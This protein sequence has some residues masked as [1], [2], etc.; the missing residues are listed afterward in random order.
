MSMKDSF[1]T[2]GNTRHLVA[3]ELLPGLE[4]LPQFEL[5]EKTLPLV[6][7]GG[8]RANMALP[9][10]S[11]AQQAV[12]CEQRFIPS[13]DHSPDVR[14]LIYT[15]PGNTTSA[16]LP[17]YLHMHGGGYVLGT[18]EISDGSNRSFA[19]ELN[20]IIVSVDYRL[21]PETTYPGALEDCYAALAWL[22]RNAQQLGVDRSRIAIGGES[23]GGGHAAALALLARERGEYPI[24][25]Q[26]LD[27]PMIDDRTGSVS[28][29]HPHCGEFVW[30]PANNRFG[31]RALL[32]VEPGS[33]DVPVAAVPARAVDL[34]GLPPTFIAVG[35]LDLF[36]EEDLEYARRLIRVGVPTEL[37]VIPGAYHG[38]GVAGG[39]TPQVQTSQRLRRAALA[40][41]FAI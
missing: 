12:R 34:S 32:G 8:G 25:L 24:C 30:P 26:L 15:P 14:V 20:C 39:N 9:A 40:R 33:A 23:A 35:A 5:S 4:A 27:A 38:F 2:P 7:G 31:W 10:L 28:E 17:A 37:Y 29:P 41:A 16:L 18:P 13:T 21:A 19:A 11:P 3:P 1:P 22:H 6:R 36:L